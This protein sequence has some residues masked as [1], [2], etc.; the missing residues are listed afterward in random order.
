MTAG[1][2][3]T[4][5][6]LGKTLLTVFSIVL[7]LI[8]LAPLVWMLGTAFSVPSFNLSSSRRYIMFRIW[9]INK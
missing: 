1:E 7:G 5:F 3:N 6:S 9:E 4:N 2:K 8:W